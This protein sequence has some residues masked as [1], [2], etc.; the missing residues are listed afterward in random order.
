ML[1]V[2]FSINGQPIKTLYAHNIGLR[3]G[4]GCEYE[5]QWEFFSAFDAHPFLKGTVIHNRDE[6]AEGLVTKILTEVIN[7]KTKK[8]ESKEL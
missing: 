1:E 3:K 7:A 6:G 4:L 2:K 8:P 5:Y